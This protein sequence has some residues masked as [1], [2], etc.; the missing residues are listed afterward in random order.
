MLTV[1]EM[2]VPI[3]MC[4]CAYRVD[5]ER[6]FNAAFLLAPLAI[7]SATSALAGLD[8]EKC[9]HKGV[10]IEMQN[11]VLRSKLLETKR[12]NSAYRPTWACWGAKAAQPL[13]N[14]RRMTVDRNMTL[15][16]LVL[17]M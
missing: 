1:S 17:V 5:Y 7:S 9:T 14:A 15:T 4:S 13:A 16:L 12:K 8:D 2:G 10:S 3:V 11:T 6:T